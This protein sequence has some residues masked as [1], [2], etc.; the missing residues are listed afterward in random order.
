VIKLALACA[1]LVGCGDP[2]AEGGR[3]IGPA[4]CVSGTTCIAVAGS[5]LRCLRTC[6][7]ATTFL[8]DGGAVCLAVEGS[9]SGACAFGGSIPLGEECERTSEC[10][11]TAICVTQGGD[12]LCREAC[13]P[14]GTPACACVPLTSGGG[15]CPPDPDAG[16]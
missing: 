13:D 2:V 16:P 14:A 11:A 10:G 6:D 5:G 8:C 12:L 15:Y 7:P 1:L 3:C 9:T 4:D